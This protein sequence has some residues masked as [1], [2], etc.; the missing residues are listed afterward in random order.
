MYKP[1]GAKVYKHGD[2]WGLASKEKGTNPGVDVN[3]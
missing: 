2:L 3:N 1:H